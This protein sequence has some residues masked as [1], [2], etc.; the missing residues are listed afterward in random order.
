MEASKPDAIQPAIVDAPKPETLA[1]SA[2]VIEHIEFQEQLAVQS[3]PEKLQFQPT[4]PDAAPY[5]AAVREIGW[6]AYKRLWQL[7][8]VMFGFTFPLWVEWF[9]VQDRT[10]L[11][12]WW[13]RLA[14]RWTVWYANRRLSI[15]DPAHRETQRAQTLREDLTALGPTFIKIGQTLATRP[16]LLPLA[17]IKELSLLQDEVPC[18]PNELAWARIRE[19][20][21]RAPHELFLSIDSDPLAAAS[22]GQVYRA[23]LKSGEEVVIKIQRPNLEEILHLDL[24]VLRYVAAVLERY[25]E[26]I[27]G[28]DWLGVVDEFD[29]MIHEETDYE[30]EIE[31]AE[32]FRQNFAD[33]KD[34]VYVPRIYPELSSRRI[35]TMEYIGGLKLTDLEGLK[36]AGHQPIEIIRLLT[37]TYLKQL[38]EDGF[39]HADPHPGNLR[40]MPNGR[41]AFFDFGMVGQITDEMRS[42]MIDA[43]FH[44]VERDI[45]G[46]VGDAIAL[47][48]LR[49]GFDPEEFRPV[50]ESIFSRYV[51]VKIGMIRF[52][53]L[54][55]AVADTIYSFPFYIPANFTFIIRALTTIEGIGLLVEPKFSFF[56][57]ARPHAKEFMLKRESAHLR[58]QILGKLIRGEEGNIAWNK[59]W[60]LVKLAYRH[61]FKKAPSNPDGVS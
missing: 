43:F 55:A 14:H 53:D 7:F 38:L 61:Y 6:P 41:L 45:V 22:L 17:Y 58:N 34:T 2:L 3:V 24:T 27:Q 11:P 8:R 54:M 46:I 12:R 18:F 60:N 51:G 21:G 20:L 32:R 48:F 29:R 40:M 57:A 4:P 10:A 47:G 15:K 52:Q 13:Q 37:R 16:D 5:W 33:W 59:V 9:S 44:I 25:P 50:V 26:W 1:P 30:K 35:I 39:F 36:A 31:N 23:R 42:G 49:P 56:D 19:D 28:I